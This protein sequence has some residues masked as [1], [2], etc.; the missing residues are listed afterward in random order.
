MTEII[1]F[2]GS[3]SELNDERNL[4]IGFINRLNIDI[5]IYNVTVIPELWEFNSKSFEE[6]RKQD[7]FNEKLVKSTF[8]VFMFGKNIGKYT[9]E[10][11]DLAY[12]HKQNFGTPK[13]ILAYFKNVFIE[14]G[15]LDT[16]GIINLTKVIDLKKYIDEEIGQIYDTFT[17]PNELLL[18][19][20]NEINAFIRPLI[21]SSNPLSLPENFYRLLDSYTKIEQSIL[22][23]EKDDIIQQ[24]YDKLHLLYHY[25]YKATLSENEFYDR[26]QKL[27]DATSSGSIIRAI[28]VMLKCE[29]DDSDEEINFLK[30]N[31][32]AV[33]RRVTLERI[34]VVRKSE[35]HRILQMTHIK[36]H[37]ND[38]TG[39]LKSYFVER[40]FLSKNDPTLLKEI[41]DGF[42]LFD[43]TAL[44]DRN[45]QTG[46]R[47]YLVTDINQ[48]QELNI[49]FEKLKGHTVGLKEYM[50]NIRLSHVKKEMISIF[51]TTKCNLN[52]G[53]CFTNKNSV[54]HKHQTIDINFAKKGIDDY[55]KTEYLRHIRFFGAGE[56]TTEFLLIKEICDYA[57]NKSNSIATFEIQTNGVFNDEIAHWIGTNID[58]VWI[59][60]DGTPEIQDK[61]RPCLDGKKSSTIIENNIRLIKNS[62]DSMVGIRATITNENIFK[63]KDI[64]DYF[65]NLDIKNIWVD[66]I[67]P[68]VGEKHLK[69]SFNTMKFAEEYLDACKYAENNNIFYGSILTCN[70]NDEV[71][72]HCRA[73]IP[74]PHLTTDGYVSACDMALF[75]ADNNHMQPLIYGHWDPKTNKIIYDNEKIRFIKSRNLKNLPKCNDCHSKHHCGGYCLGEVLNEKGSMFEQKET[76]CDAIRFLDKNM[77]ESQK[78]YTYLHP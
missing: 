37:I 40:E 47:G 76:V 43:K 7:A 22:I 17:E 49:L 58:V 14:T 46:T 5:R 66:P 2:I 51:V 38:K 65:K 61:H 30:A 55:F 63:Q 68:S 73:C 39:F 44:L 52:C 28:S 24:A 53:Y 23:K 19:F 54:P 1:I 6:N 35:S 36:A 50:N 64:I 26:C 4:L 18:K 13:K 34:F 57:R 62:G 3:S 48:I 33:N 78:K 12:N 31:L 20:S 70:F 32:D 67:F 45:P 74:V 42:L 27:M 59:S 71:S 15:N 10:E 16:L 69:E 77:T 21:K 72:Q 29:W 60:C 11:F 8:A 75:G 9:K 56:P 41:G 25:N